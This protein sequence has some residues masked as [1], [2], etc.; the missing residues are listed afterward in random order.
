MNGKVIKWSRLIVTAMARALALLSL[1]LAATAALAATH[2]YDV[3][4]DVDSSAA[5]GC[6]V[7]TA[8]GTASGI[9]QMVRVTVTTTTSAATVT[10]LQQLSCISG[11][12]FAAPIALTGAPYALALGNGVGGTTAVEA[13]LPL[14]AIP[15]NSDPT[16]PTVIRLAAASLAGDAAA[17]ALLPLTALQIAAGVPVIS[18][19]PV[20]QV[21]T[22]G[23]AALLALAACLAGLGML[24][25]RRFGKGALHGAVHA[26]LAVSIG[27]GLFGLGSALTY[28]ITKD[29]L[30]T[31]WVGA[32]ALITG[33]RGDAVGTPAGSADLVALF[34]KVDGAELALRIDADVRLESAANVAPVVSAGGAQ[35]ATLASAAGNVVVTVSG[36]ASDDGL[37][38][39]PG[40]LTLNWSKVSGPG[41]AIFANAALAATTVTINQAGSYVL[42]LTASDSLLSTS[43][44]VPVTVNSAPVVGNLAPVITNLPS[45][46][47]LTLPTNSATLAPIVTDDGLPV[48]A[49]LTYRWTQVSGLRPVFFGVDTN[50]PP[51]LLTTALANAA[52]E[53]SARSTAAFF[54][55]D[56]PG[57]YVLRFTASDTLLSSSR[58]VTVVVSAAAASAPVIGPFA[59]QTVRLGETLTLALTGSDA[60]PRD[61]LTYSLTAAPSGA[62]LTPVGSARL[63][64]TPTDA[65]VGA[66]AVTLRVTDSTNQSA[67]TSFTVTVVSAN[68]PPKFTDPSKAD[69][70]TAVGA[71]FTRQL[72]AIDPDVGDSA[73]YAL[74]EGPAGLSVAAN[75]AMSWQPGAT[76]LGVNYVKVKV[77]DSAGGI[78]VAMFKLEVKA[79]NRPLARDDNY[80]ARLGE[81]I[82]VSAADG[83]LKNDVDG[84]GDPLTAIKLTDPDRGTLN[85]FNA[86]GGF[87]YTAPASLPPS[88]RLN[89]VLSWRKAEVGST[90]FPFAADLDGDGKA[91]F[92]RSNFGVLYANRGSDGSVLWQFDPSIAT[93]VD[94]TGCTFFAFLG[95][96]ALGDVT[97]GGE[98]DLIMPVQCSKDG[99]VASGV[100]DRYLAINASAISATGKVA[101]RWLGP[102]MSKPHP[103]AYADTLATTTTLPNPPIHPFEAT[104]S[105]LTLPTLAKITPTG[106]TKIVTRQLW[107]T[108]DG[109]Y[110]ATPQAAGYTYAA[111][112]TATGLPADE[113][114]AC[115]ATYVLSATTG[116]VE[117]ILTAPNTRNEG[118][119]RNSFGP[120]RNNPPIVADLDGD[121]QVEIISGGE[122][123]KLVAGTWT[124]AWQA[125]FLNNAGV[126]TTF[127]PDSV[128]VADLDG[129][130]K[131]EVIMHLLAR[132]NFGVEQQLGGIYIFSHDGTLLRKIPFALNGGASTSGLVS[133]ADVDGDG[134]PEILHSADGGLFAYRGDGSLVWAKQL[135]DIV[136][137]VPTPAGGSALS[138]ISVTTTAAP[139]YVYDL[140]LD[141]VPEVIVQGARRLFILNGRTGELRW[142]IDTESGGYFLGNPL[143]VDAD[144]DGHVD[145]LVNVSERWN[146]S[147]LSGGPVDCAGNTLKISGGNNNWAPGP[148]LQNQLNFRASAINAAAVIRYDGSVRREFRQPIQ[149]GTV[150]DPR[151]AQSARFTYKA[152]D[153]AADSAAA[154]VTIDIKPANRPPV[155]TSTPPTAFSEVGLSGVQTVYTITAFDPDP[156][157][158]VHYEL[159][160]VQGVLPF[161]VLPT[162]DAVTGKVNVL[163]CGASCRDRILLL[164]VAAVDAQ[165]ARTEQSMLINFTLT[166]VAV[167]NVVGQTRP[168]ASAQLE[169]VPLTPS[170]ISQVFNAA[171]AGTVIAQDPIAGAA[172]VPLL[173]TV[174]L[175]L[176]KGLAPVLVPGVVGLPLT[177]AQSRLSSAGFTVSVLRQFSSTVA[178]GIVINQSPT[179]GLL[180]PP[181]SATLNVSAGSGLLLDLSNTVITADQS[182]TLLPRAFDVDG[183]ALALP[184]V[185]YS[186]VA[187]RSPYLGTLPTVAGTTMSASLGT[188]GAFTVIATDSA[189][190]RTASA[191]FSVMRAK[192]TGKNT[193]GA[194]FAALMSTLTNFDGYTPALRAARL[195]N[196]EPQ[197]KAILAQMVNTW[198]ALDIS[199][200]R[201]ATP[202]AL[203]VGFAPTLEYLQTVRPALQPTTDDVLS[204]Q[205]LRDAIDDLQAITAAFRAPGGGL[206][207]LRNLMDQ[208]LDRVR[209]IDA[210]TMSEYGLVLNAPEMI[211]L[212]SSVIPDFY[213]ALTDEIAVVAGLPRRSTDFPHLKRG[214]EQSKSTLAEVVTTLAVDFIVDKIVEEAEK[215]YK[216]AKK[217]AKDIA[218][219]TGWAAAMSI[220]RGTALPFVQ[221]AEIS[222]VVSGASLSF[223]SFSVPHAFME[224]PMRINHPL[225]ATV[226][227]VGPDL[228]KGTKDF[229]TNA[230]TGL[231]E[232]LKKGASLGRDALTN[233][234][235]FQSAD[236]LFELKEQLKKGVKELTGLHGEYKIV[237]DSLYQSPTG[238]DRGGCIFVGAPTCTQ[239]LFDDGIGSVYTYAPPDGLATLS[240][241][242]L[243][244]LIMIEDKR[245]GRMFFATPLFIPQKPPTPPMP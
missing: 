145:I 19:A 176:S 85:S 170:V 118:I 99:T 128:A 9:E 94:L 140:D 162:V 201:L 141:G 84:D 149:L 221:G 227:I 134:I 194:Q 123:W 125:T 64:F 156:G 235:R 83:V 186:V 153:G 222:E 167:P 224:V 61:N 28:A 31:D 116:A 225:L 185:T 27:I 45:T 189:N 93:H 81:T 113:G 16:R 228:V 70:T 40:A 236:D 177:L 98:I 69:A 206:L 53:T 169:A 226:T 161:S 211:V 243:P 217:F 74:I 25:I 160:S 46:L 127:E 100:A 108:N 210:L 150:I 79:N 104:S 15:L 152:N 215:P 76:Q 200:L 110:Y 209:R 20:L 36:S 41:T 204:Q 144:G 171:A 1:A 238:V 71:A 241:I 22:L 165:G 173:A 229:V 49:A 199:S 234:D 58:E 102:R 181:G 190:A 151:S 114:R 223:R 30:T 121:G 12:S 55:F 52:R 230:L 29:G 119:I 5:T 139:I 26:L 146:C 86:N 154:T 120:T 130:G 242:P 147:A 65:Q 39:P 34:A 182:I 131:A 135:P 208:F 106:A 109:P 96:F 112:R 82:T 103:G 2:R 51:S 57:T 95:D 192:P 54:D 233:P 197:M 212:M 6:S 68:R 3:L 21:P 191:T 183:N 35:T 126:A 166:Q 92:V 237:A 59:N 179:A 129:D 60:N 13:T 4:I 42:R 56:L 17:D 88:D 240:G 122:V 175:T 18:V 66:H 148:K 89:P 48:G 136:S 111:C 219:Q 216:N 158:T 137:D 87:S 196:D 138:P 187:A 10:A 157:D 50:T 33:T 91:D 7:A 163:M 62:L 80:I 47:S 172:N 132:N 202:I 133:V 159:V 178:A 107:S 75:G 203:P 11:S 32:A 244:I 164:I 63:A 23:Q 232:S 24:L 214:G 73:T 155:I 239:V 105:Y 124:L 90:V 38:N 77:T 78:D 195:A 198:R 44:D 180:L 14:T 72:V 117:Q 245:S 231:W 213:E 37:P 43:S 101:A 184:S 97:G 220:A 143:L 218:L 115:K 174:R 205:V 193:N 67:Q 188:L 168:A 8:K 207:N 142:S